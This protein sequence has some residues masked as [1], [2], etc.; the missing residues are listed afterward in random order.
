MHTFPT[1]LVI[2]SQLSIRL[3]ETTSSIH[4]RKVN[5]IFQS[6]EIVRVVCV[7]AVCEHTHPA[8]SFISLS[9]SVV[10]K[11]SKTKWKNFWTMGIESV[12]VLARNVAATSKLS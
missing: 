9:R 7:C 3:N 5:K 6:D 10:S 4:T 1:C 12:K 8:Q 11:C 2:F